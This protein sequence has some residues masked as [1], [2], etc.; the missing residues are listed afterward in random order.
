MSSAFK[1]GDMVIVSQEIALP[2]NTLTPLLWCICDCSQDEPIAYIPYRI[3]TGDAVIVKSILEGYALIPEDISGDGYLQNIDGSLTGYKG[4]GDVEYPYPHCNGYTYYLNGYY[5]YI[6]KC[7]GF[8]SNPLPP[9]A[10]DIEFLGWTIQMKDGNSAR[11]IV[12][13]KAAYEYV[14]VECPTFG[15][16][17]NLDVLY[18]TSSSVAPYPLR[19]ARL[20]SNTIRIQAYPGNSGTFG[21]SA[22]EGGYGEIGIRIGINGRNTPGSRIDYN[23]PYVIQ[24]RMVYFTVKGTGRYGNYQ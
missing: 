8:Q 11:I 19:W 24:Y 15:D 13:S 14:D 18:F 7:K 10:Y 21:K 4:F 1:V 3:Y 5:Y 16:G 9:G 6:G 17:G 22:V 12:H 2:L 20:N 23:D